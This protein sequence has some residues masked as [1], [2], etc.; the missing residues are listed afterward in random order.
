MSAGND[1]AAQPVAKMEGGMPLTLNERERAFEAKFAHDET[2]RFLV[3]ARRDKLLA[4]WA[5]VTLRLSDQAEMKLLNALLAISNKP[6]HDQMVA[7]HLALVFAR[8]GHGRQ[9]GQ[10]AAAIRMCAEQAR[11]QLIAAPFDDLTQR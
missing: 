1:R 7:D 11:Q 9:E 6:A 8:R 10:I 3:S 2:F 5:A 4:H